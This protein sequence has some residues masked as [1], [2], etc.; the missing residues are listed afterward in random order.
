[1]RSRQEPIKDDTPA[2]TRPSIFN[3]LRR[4][5]A[6]PLARDVEIDDP[7]SVEVHRRMIL[8]KPFLRRIYEEWY[9]QIM[10]ALPP[11]K[12]AILELGSG[13]GFLRE[14]IRG[15]V[16]SDVRRHAGVD[17][18]LDALALP[19]AA[20]SLRAIV[21]VDVLHHLAEPRRFFS[22]ARRCVRSGGAIVM[23][24]PWVTKWSKL[25]YTNLHHEPFRPQSAQ[26]EFSTTGPMSGANGALPWI[27]FERDR[28]Q[29]DREFPEWGVQR[30]E[31]QMPF[32][33]LVSGGVSMRSLAPGWSF[34]LCRGFEQA[35][36]PWMRSLGM[37]AMIVL[38][39]R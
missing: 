22:E 33:Y 13:T 26:W 20:G 30:I 1:M 35:L 23:I 8:S 5:L 24:E 19:V 36:K 11:G 37:F 31:I 34:G 12:G 38:S 27:L 10:S 18:V 4:R 21:M 17:V 32:R 15:V 14:Y 16:T 25:I 29:F 6:H 39:R 7:S 28:D 9:D 3:F 2:F